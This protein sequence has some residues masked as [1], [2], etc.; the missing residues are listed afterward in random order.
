M[1]KVCSRPG[2]LTLVL[3]LMLAGCAWWSGRGRVVTTPCD[4]VG[5]RPHAEGLDG[6]AVTVQWT[7][8]RLP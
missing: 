5:L 3:A 4:H 1:D 2:P 6:V 7:T 8:C